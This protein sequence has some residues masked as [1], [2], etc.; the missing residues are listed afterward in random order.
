MP[1]V[2]VKTDKPIP[3]A[4]LFEAMEKLN[5]IEI[6]APINCGDVI[7]KDFIEDGTNLVACRDIQ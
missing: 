1:L 4:R 3:K 6:P 7:V 2:P 5:R